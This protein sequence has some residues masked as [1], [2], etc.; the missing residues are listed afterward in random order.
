MATLTKSKRILLV[1]DD[2]LA[3]KALATLLRSSGHV[4][5]DY[6]SAEDA[7]GQH[8]EEVDV[9]LLDINLPGERGTEFARR[10][11]EKHPKLRLILMTGARV[12]HEELLPGSTVFTK[13]LDCNRLLNV[14]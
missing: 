13:P 2:A 12:N 9:A 10:L 11:K 8:D 4:V 14:L 3:L 1:E 6:P 7:E 5:W